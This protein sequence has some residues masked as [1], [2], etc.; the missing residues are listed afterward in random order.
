MSAMFLST[1]ASAGC[2]GTAGWFGTSF[3]L[4]CTSG[5]YK[6]ERVIRCIQIRVGPSADSNRVLAEEP[7]ELGAVVSGAGGPGADLEF[8]RAKH[9]ESIRVR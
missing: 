5:I 3:L 7:L 6:I 8:R 1:S 2:C 4:V 9:N